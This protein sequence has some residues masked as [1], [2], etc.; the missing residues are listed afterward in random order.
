MFP[1][2]FLT[3]SLRISAWGVCVFLAALAVLGLGRVNAPARGLPAALVER[4]WPWLLLGGFAGAHLYYLVAVADW[5][6]RRAAPGVV[7]NI[8]NGTAVQGGILGGA[9]AAAAYLWWTGGSSFLS[10]CDVLAPGGAWAQAL[11]RVGCFAAG[12]CYGRP[13]SL[14]LGAR[15]T[16]PYA[17]PGTPRGVLLHPAQLY[18]AVL[19]ACLAAFLQRQLR[20]R[21]ES[22]AVFALYLTGASLIRFLVQF[23]RDDDRGRLT[24]G[25]AHSQF[26][27]IVLAA[28]GVALYTNV[29]FRREAIP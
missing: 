8:F 9:C 26:L 17:D 28:A 22:G 2:L 13:T 19:D 21:K 10:L 15:F 18:E 11:A 16:S 24:L 7:L 4:L 3:P 14:F 29:V 23:F 25:L 12:C 6:L 1:L 5:P 27:A 20:R